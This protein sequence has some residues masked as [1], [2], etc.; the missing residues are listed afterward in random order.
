MATEDGYFL[1]RR[2][3]GLDLSDYTAVRAALDAFEAPRKPHTARQSQQAY[4]LGQ[5]F[6]RA[7]RPLQMLRDLILDGTPLLQKVVGESSPGEILKQLAEI[8][9]AEQAFIAVQS[10][11]R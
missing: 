1:G 6:H 11:N 4:I 5:V 10:S 8:D 9:A 2:L 7:P 3:A